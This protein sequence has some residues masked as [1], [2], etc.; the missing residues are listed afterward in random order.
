M[1]MKKTTL[2]AAML[3]S[4]AGA[5]T[6]V[7]ALSIDVTTMEFYDA[8]GNPQ[9]FGGGL[10][11]SVVGGVSS[12][13]TGT[14]SSG[15]TPFFGTPWTATTEMWTDTVRY[16]NWSG[17]SASGAFNYDFWLTDNQV[18]V[19]IYFTW[20]AASEI[21]V[22]Q[23]FDCTAGAGACVGVNNDAAHPGV[24]G[25]EMANGPFAGQHATFKGTTLDTMPDVQ[26]VPVPAA[27]WLFGSGLLGLVGVTRRKKQ[28]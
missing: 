10:N 28:A 15:P 21:A 26:A 14:M 6:S 18:A 4:L 25:T 5:S 16:G 13:L 23:I 8:G 20:G 24:P 17:T 19:G 11:T 22:L 9:F 7:Q 1:N 27:V 2:A 3:M 12:D